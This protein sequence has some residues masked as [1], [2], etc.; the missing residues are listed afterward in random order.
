MQKECLL[1]PLVPE[2]KD[3][4]IERKKKENLEKNYN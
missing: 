3:V 4:Q 2:K 1:A